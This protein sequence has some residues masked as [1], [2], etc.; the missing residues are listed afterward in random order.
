VQK[1]VHFQPVSSAQISTHISAQ[2]G[3]FLDERAKQQLR[4]S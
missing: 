3:E 4:A 1:F 2:V